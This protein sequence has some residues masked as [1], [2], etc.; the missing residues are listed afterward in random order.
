MRV[1]PSYS[2]IHTPNAKNR[3][4]SS[5]PLRKRA[6]IERASIVPQIH[7]YTRGTQGQGGW[8]WSCSLHIYV[9]YIAR[10]RRR[11]KVRAHGKREREREVKSKKERGGNLLATN[12]IDCN[13][14]PFIGWAQATLALYTHTALGHFNWFDYTMR[15]HGL[16]PIINLAHRGCACLCLGTF[17]IKLRRTTPRRGRI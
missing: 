4:T 6:I 11:L 3:R 15:A 16:H 1:Q 5:G 9:Y 10:E 8:C 2:I 7:I 14:M 12:S 17:V 13:T